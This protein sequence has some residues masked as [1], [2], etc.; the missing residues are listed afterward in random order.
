[1]VSFYFKEVKKMETLILQTIFWVGMAGAMIIPLRMVGH[2]LDI[3][4]GGRN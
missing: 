3:L 1:M 2:L 4:T